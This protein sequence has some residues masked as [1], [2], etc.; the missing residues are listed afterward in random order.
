LSDE[1]P[2]NLRPIADFFGLVGTAPVEKDFY[3]VRAIRTLAAL[4]AAPFALV[5]GGG[6]ALARAHRLVRRTSEDVDFKSC[7]PRRRRPA[8]TRFTVSED[9]YVTVSRRRFSPPGSTLIQKTRRKPHRG[10]K[11][12]TRSISFLMIQLPEQDRGCAR[13]SRLS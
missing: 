3:V 5:F 1:L 11:A 12:V 8:A 7:R 4:D 2:G 6:T 10:M 9:R 13:R